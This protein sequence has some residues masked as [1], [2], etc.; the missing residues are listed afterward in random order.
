[1]TAF[2]GEW[3]PIEELPDDWDSL[4]SPT[5]QSLVIAW[6]ERSLQ[7]Q[8]SDALEQ[9]KEG[10]RQEW[11]SEVDLLEYLYS[12]DRGTTQI[13]LEKGIEISLPTQS[14]ETRLAELSIPTTIEALFGFVTQER[15]LSAFFIRELHQV[16]ARNQRTTWAQNPSGGLI[17]VP[18]LH[19]R[20]KTL[21]NNPKRPDGKITEYC[22]PEQVESEIERLVTMHRQHLSANVPPEIE[23]AW[24]HHRFTQ[25]HPFQDGNGRVA[26]MLASL[27]FL[28]SGLFPV[29]VKRHDRQ[30]Y[31]F[32]SEE[33]DTGNLSRL[34]NLF[35]RLQERILVKGLGLRA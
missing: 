27:I 9:F 6:R 10:L 35:S 3:Q 25:T 4:R 11:L 28:R 12:T 32:A 22:P 34:V 16:L 13:F 8:G 29:V 2:P 19:G 14:S 7:L 21:P 23:A 5:L 15:S 1:M 26:R 18:L 20:W 24:L 31:I 17:E 33:A 30:E